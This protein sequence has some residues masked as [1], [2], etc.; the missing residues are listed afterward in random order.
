[1]LTRIAELVRR[2][3]AWRQPRRA[4]QAADPLLTSGPERALARAVLAYYNQ[5]G[6]PSL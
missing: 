5:V 6:D 1:M 4:G 2:V 3:T